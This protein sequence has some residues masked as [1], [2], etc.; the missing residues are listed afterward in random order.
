MQNYM[1]RGCLLRTMT[2]QTELCWSRDLVWVGF[3]VLLSLVGPAPMTL[4]ATPLME[5]TFFISNLFIY[6]LKKKGFGFN[7]ILIPIPMLMIIIINKKEKW[8]P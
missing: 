8:T 2:C 6:L 7:I 1:R 3:I 4:G 5:P